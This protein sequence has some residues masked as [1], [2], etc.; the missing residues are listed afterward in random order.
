MLT[1]LYLHRSISQIGVL[2]ASFGVGGFLLERYRK[3]QMAFVSSYL[4]SE[5]KTVFLYTAHSSTLYK[6]SMFLAAESE[7]HRTAKANSYDSLSAS[8]YFSFMLH[9]CDD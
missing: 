1:G 8:I 9:A 7:H 5:V 3:R 2:I 4:T 6:F